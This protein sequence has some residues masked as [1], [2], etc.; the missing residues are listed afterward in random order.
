MNGLKESSPYRWISY[1]GVMPCSGVACISD[2]F[3]M[4]K[5]V[6]PAGV[7]V[8]GIEDVTLRWY[9]KGGCVKMGDNLFP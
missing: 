1:S 8:V 2:V 5:L 9:L 3:V 6:L 7:I 4:M